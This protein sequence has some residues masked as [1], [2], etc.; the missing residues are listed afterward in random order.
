[1]QK[2]NGCEADDGDEH[3]GEMDVRQSAADLVQLEERPVSVRGDAEHLSEYGDADLE[4]DTGEKSDEHGL[5][6][7][8]GDKAEF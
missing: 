7:E 2:E 3:R 8:V 6:E 1:M 4:A 5:G